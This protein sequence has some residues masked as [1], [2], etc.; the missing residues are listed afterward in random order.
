MEAGGTVT[1]T[2]FITYSSEVFKEN[3]VPLHDAEATSLLA[4]LTP[5]KYD[6]TTRPGRRL[7]GFVAE[8]VPASFVVETEGLAKGKGVDTMSI[9]ATL[10]G[11][12]RA[13]QAALSQLQVRVDQLESRGT[14]P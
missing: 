13:Q 7:M 12:V 10:A 5:V 8:N 3:I 6:L 1:A 9:I 14:T 11:V 2:Q 4:Q